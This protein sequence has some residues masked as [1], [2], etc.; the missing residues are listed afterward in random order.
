[1]AGGRVALLDSF[2]VLEV[3]DAATRVAALQTKQVDFTEG[4]PNDFY[5]TVSADGNLK[6]HLIPNW[7]I[8]NLATNKLWRCSIMEYLWC[9]LLLWFYMGY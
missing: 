5:G 1:M 4:L 7:A 2:E 8:P 6:V 9:Y 3:P